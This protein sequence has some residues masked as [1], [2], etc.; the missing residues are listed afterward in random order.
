MNSEILRPR[1]HFTPEKGYMNDPNGLVKYKDTWFLFY[2]WNPTDTC[3]GNTHWGMAKSRDLLHWEHFPAAI[4]PDDLDGNIFSGS[5]VVDTRNVSGMKQ[6]EDDPILLFYTGTGVRTPPPIIGKTPEGRPLFPKD[7]VRPDTRQCIA[8]STDGG[9]SFQKYGGNPILPQYAPLNRDPKV[10]FVPE[11]GAFV[12]GLFIKE[13]EYR[14]FWS[15]DLLHWQEGQ[16]LLF[17]KAAECPDLFCLCLDGDET[18]KKWIFFGSP[19]CYM[20]GHFENREYIPETGEIEGPI[21]MLT[22]FSIRHPDAYAPQTYFLP[23]S[24]RVVQLSWMNTHFPGAPF[25]SQMSLPWELTLV[26]AP[27]GPRIRRSFAKETETLR[28]EEVTVRGITAQELNSVLCQRLPFG[29]NPEPKAT[30][31]ILEAKVTA[32]SRFGFAIHGVPIWFDGAALLFPTG[33]MELPLEGDQLRLHLVAD[34]GSLELFAC[35]GLAAFVYSSVMD[36]VKPEIQ[37]LFM[38]NTEIHVRKYSL[39]L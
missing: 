6:G 10:N 23:G 37:M 27:D 2:Q 20:V 1:V 18:R 15:E 17:S 35:G 13:H 4:C 12:M 26:S 32:Q 7:W 19:D 16:R 8:C 31:V 9:K 22:E 11:C 3:P 38:E 21:S 5:G 24:F 30:E 34:V 33:R 28:R 39:S 36:C 25:Q 29:K 14:L